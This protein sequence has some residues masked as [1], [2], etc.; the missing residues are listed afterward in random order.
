MVF[1]EKV[2]KKY[3]SPVASIEY[4]TTNHIVTTSG[5]QGEGGGGSEIDLSEF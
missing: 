5:G 4:F 1:E 2:K 3:A